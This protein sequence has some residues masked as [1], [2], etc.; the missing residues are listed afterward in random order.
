MP[1]D[2]NITTRSTGL[3]SC[4]AIALPAVTVRTNAVAPRNAGASQR[5]QRFMSTPLPGSRTSMNLYARCGRRQH[6][7][8][9]P[10]EPHALVHLFERGSGGGLR[11]FG[12]SREQRAEL[13]L[14]RSELLVTLLDGAEQSD[15]RL[16]D[17]LLERAVALAVVAGLDLGDR[18]A[19]RDR[20]DLDQIGDPG[21][22][23]AGVAH[24]GARVR[25][26][27]LELLAHD[28]GRVEQ[29]HRALRG[30]AC[31]GHL[32]LWFLEIHDPRTDLGVDPLGE[33]EDLAEASVEP[34]RDVP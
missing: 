23:L 22:L 16:G 7:R 30:T 32:L 3:P 29:A 15:D 27:A 14:V 8:S 18:L 1:S 19:G 11:L 24:L 26:G 28:L 5:A 33:L 21:L 4:F 9:E 13:A 17:L 25:D 12:A 34:L 10:G 6:D 2:E 31:G 20:H